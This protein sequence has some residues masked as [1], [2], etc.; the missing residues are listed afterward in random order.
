M[1]K[2]NTCVKCA[3]TGQK[4]KDFNNNNNN[5]NNL[6]V[7]VSYSLTCTVGSKVFGFSLDKLK[8]KFS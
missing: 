7:C 8:H 5:N 4:K 3:N 1:D 2:V 6:M